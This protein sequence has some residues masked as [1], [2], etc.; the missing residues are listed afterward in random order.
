[1]ATIFWKV[2]HV[3]KDVNDSRKMVGCPKAHLHSTPWQ[4]LYSLGIHDT[5]TVDIL[6]IV[7]IRVRAEIA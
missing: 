6:I 4:L 7:P 3:K 1:V 5:V 2:H